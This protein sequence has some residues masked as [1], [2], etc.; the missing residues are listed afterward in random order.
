[1]KHR[2]W[3]RSGNFVIAVIVFPTSLLGRC[4]EANGG[5]RSLSLVMTPPSG[6]DADTSCADSAR[7]GDV[8]NETRFR[9]I[10]ICSGA[11]GLVFL[12]FLVVPI[13]HRRGETSS[14][15]NQPDPPGLPDPELRG[16]AL[17]PVT[18]RTYR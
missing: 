7:G 1:M 8:L 12:L 5:V 11:D 2:T 10:T 17:S 9:W 6:S 3:S 16:A 13:S 15:Q 4:R 18:W 14:L